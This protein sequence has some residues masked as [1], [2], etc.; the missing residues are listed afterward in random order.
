[1]KKIKKEVGKTTKLIKGKYKGYGVYYT[2]GGQ[3][4]P[5]AGWY[6]EKSKNGVVLD[7]LYLEE[8]LPKVNKK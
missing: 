5:R 6:L 8:A 2:S 7:I 4:F 3:I 1:M